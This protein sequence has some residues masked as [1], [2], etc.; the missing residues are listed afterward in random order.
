M[1]NFIFLML[2]ICCSMTLFSYCSRDKQPL[3]PVAEIGDDYLPGIVHVVM[4]DTLSLSYFNKFLHN[5]NLITKGLVMGGYFSIDA[6]ADTSILNTIAQQITQ[7]ELADKINTRKYPF[8]GRSPEKGC[9]IIE[10]KAGIDS[11]S[12]QNMLDEI[13]GVSILEFFHFY[14]MATIKV[15]VDTEVYWVNKLKRYPF[16]I[17]AE[18]SPKIYLQTD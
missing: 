14:K 7:S 5:H 11:V 9:L 17:K 6:E 3:I 10:F 15:P 12:I 16:I 13:D 8:P 1:K 18:L 4:A 2:V